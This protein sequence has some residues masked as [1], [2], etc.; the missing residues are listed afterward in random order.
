[1]IQDANNIGLS[2]GG[3]I[4]RTFYAVSRQIGLRGP[5]DR[6]GPRL[7]DLRHLFATTTLLRWYR[8]GQDPA[9]RLL[10]LSVY[11]GHVHVADTQ[12]YLEAAPAPLRAAMR[13]LERRW[14]ARP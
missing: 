4:H 9:R 7:H 11:L 3:D 12:W 6:R 5:A 2:D 13:R 1:M 8:A 10:L 14:E